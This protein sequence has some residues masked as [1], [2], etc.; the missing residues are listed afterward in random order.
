MLFSCSK[1]T[2]I[3]ASASRAKSENLPKSAISKKYEPA[4]L[5]NEQL[6]LLSLI[7]DVALKDNVPQVHAHAVV[8]KKDGTAHG[9]HL[10]QAHIR[11]TCE[12]VLVES[13]AHLQ[14]RIDQ[15]SGLPL[16][17][18]SACLS[19]LVMKR[20]AND[21]EVALRELNAKISDAE[22][23]GNREWLATII[24]PR[25]AFQRADAARTLDDQVAYLQ[26][27]QSGGTRVTTCIEPIELYGDRAIAKCIVKVG[28]R[29]PPTSWKGISQYSPVCTERGTME[30]SRL[31]Q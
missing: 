17:D 9:G 10:L 24:A 6:E 4:V 8:G 3:T 7:G 29:C 2:P 23:A 13:P 25:L 1:S 12:I 31:G 26:K 15:E 21:D 19:R 18:A 5:L 28:E 11:P 30:T 16:I 27:V 14:R 22:N 20:S